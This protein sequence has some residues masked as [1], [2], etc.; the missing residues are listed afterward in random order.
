[1]VNDAQSAAIKGASVIIV[2]GATRTVR[3]TKT[4][5]TGR[6]DFPNVEPG[7]YDLTVDSP[8][9]S[10]ARLSSQ[11]V[12]VCMALTLNVRLEVGR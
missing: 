6:Y 7:T 3:S 9:F 12:D 2:E 10:T 5:E 4:N 8:G 1:L 11:K